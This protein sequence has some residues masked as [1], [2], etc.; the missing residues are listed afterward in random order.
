[1]FLWN[2]FRN[3][4]H[5][6]GGYREFAVMAVPL[7]LST[8][9]WSV[10]HFVDRMFLA[11]YSPEAIAASVPAG[12]V[13]F[14][15]L[16]LFLG[17]TSYC[18]TFVAQ[19]YGAGRYH[20]IGPAVWQGIYLALI[21]GGVMALCMPLAEPLFTLVGHDPLVRRLEI[22]YFQV[23]CLGAA[24]VLV[25][26]S[27]AGFFAGRGRPWPIMWVNAAATVVNV[28]LNYFL[29]FGHWG[30][31]E[32]GIFGAGLATVLS[33]VFASL[34]FISLA[35]R[36]KHNRIFRTLSGWRPEKMLFLRLCRFGLPVGIQFSLD[37]TSFAVFILLVGR[38]GTVSL[39]AT[40]LA[41]NINILAFMPMVGSGIAVSVLVGQYLGAN[42]PDLA[43]K[44]T[45][46]AFHLT[47]AYILSISAGYV[48]IPDLF[49]SPF[50]VKADPERF[51]EIYSLAVILLRFV[52]AFGLFDT[53]NLIFSSA[54]KG[55]GDTRFV[56]IMMAI[57]STLFLALPAYVVLVLL[58]G[59]LMVSWIILTVNVSLLGLI[60]YFRFLGG[61]WKNMRVIEE[62]PKV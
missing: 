40:N 47:L 31:P 9:A 17:T 19:Y 41:F 58:G 59:G 42:R 20:R 4:W 5:G 38:L 28:I 11:W 48:F 22:S 46:S 44:S 36:S 35:F 53:L 29:I 34:V 32:L 61:K 14:S 21:G 2:Y 33:Q 25:N 43:Q 23:L 60:F 1:M 15:G 50:A 12:I 39:A 10:Q 54:I 13:S 37:V 51:P 6:Q 18:E 62:A 26:S 49:L 7:I 57:V 8:S 56:M 27:I 24:P 16:S 52:A 3:R 55:A 30:F 45:Y